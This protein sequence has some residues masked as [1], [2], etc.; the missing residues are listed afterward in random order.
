MDTAPVI[1]EEAKNVNTIVANHIKQ[2]K[3]KPRRVVDLESEIR[4]DDENVKYIVQNYVKSI[5][6]SHYTMKMQ[7][8]KNLLTGRL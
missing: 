5:R 2:L 1:T 7:K 3:P 6:Q 4:H 8:Y